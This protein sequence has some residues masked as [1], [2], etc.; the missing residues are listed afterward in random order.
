ISQAL[1]VADHVYCMMEGRI[2]LQGRPADLTRD[3]IHEA[4]FGGAAA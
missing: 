4:Y 2:T 1:A 3:A